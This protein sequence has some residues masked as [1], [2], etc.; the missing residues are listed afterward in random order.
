[1]K[2]GPWHDNGAAMTDSPYRIAILGGGTA[3]WMVAAGLA[4]LLPA[5]DYDIALI[6]SDAI[7]TVGV[8]EAT[9][10]HIKDFN[11]MLGLDEAGFKIG[12]AHVC[13]PVTNA[14]LVCRFLLEKKKSLTYMLS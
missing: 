4:R 5:A 8:G 10:P 1:M 9:L 11:D 2:D 13:T 6:E 3:G 12:R 14:H 7:G